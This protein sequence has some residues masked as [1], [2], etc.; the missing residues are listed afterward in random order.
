MGVGGDWW[1]REGTDTGV[2][3]RVLFEEGEGAWCEGEGGGGG[4]WGE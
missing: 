1:A 2:Q 4:V 3:R